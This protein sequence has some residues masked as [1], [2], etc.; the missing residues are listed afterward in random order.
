M[1]QA[2]Q[3]IWDLTLAQAMLG[4]GTG[5]QTDAWTNLTQL[6]TQA[7]PASMYV[8]QAA[9]VMDLFELCINID[10]VQE[11]LSLVRPIWHFH[12]ATSVR[13]LELAKKIVQIL[14]FICK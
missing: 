9:D 1:H 5:Q 14:Q 10:K 11:Y 4:C 7:L 2:A 12:I 8:G 3:P 6:R 13:T